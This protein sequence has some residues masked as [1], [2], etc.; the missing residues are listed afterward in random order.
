VLCKNTTGTTAACFC[1]LRRMFAG[2]ADAQPRRT[3]EGLISDIG[4]QP[5][6]L[7]PI[8]YARNLEVG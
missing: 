4:F 8:R 7:G 2:P 1:L 5:V 6:Y 3:V